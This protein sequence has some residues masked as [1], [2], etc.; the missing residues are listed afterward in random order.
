MH[1][2]IDKHN[3]R[4]ILLF[5][6]SFLHFVM[7]LESGSASPIFFLFRWAEWNGKYRDDIRKFIKVM[8]EGKRTDFDFC[9]TY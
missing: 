6:L 3:H 2:Q 5:F 8:P 4:D 9:I 7:L 1:Y